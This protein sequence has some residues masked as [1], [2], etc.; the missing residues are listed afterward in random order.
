MLSKNTSQKDSLNCEEGDRAI[1]DESND[2][3]LLSA[4]QERQKIEENAQKLE[5]RIMLLEKERL[6]ML[7]KI[8]GVKRQASEIIKTKQ[9]IQ[10]DQ[11]L[12]KELEL[13]KQEELQMKQ[14]KIQ[15]MKAAIEV[16]LTSSKSNSRISTITAAKSVKENMQVR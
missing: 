4:K 5:N 13:K 7:K 8:Q 10:N 11:A 12:L 15:E 6:R 3:K 2:L 14:H 16:R 9:R 1:A